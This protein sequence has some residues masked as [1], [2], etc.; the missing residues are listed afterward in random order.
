MCVA[1]SELGGCEN[2]GALMKNSR[3]SFFQF[4]CHNN[5][6]GGGRGSNDKDILLV[7]ISRSKVKCQFRR[8]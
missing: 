7:T 8:R 2:Y 1:V 3:P 5:D 6:S 4:L